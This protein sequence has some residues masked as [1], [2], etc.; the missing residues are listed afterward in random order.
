MDWL[1]S[2]LP[3]I[4]PLGGLLALGVWIVR[5][6][7]VGQL[8][9]SATHERILASK[10]ETIRVL[11]EAGARRDAQTDKLLTTSETT[12]HLLRSIAPAE[13]DS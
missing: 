1:L 5:Q 12:L 7:V 13:G 10:E 11:S 4:T 8:I 9:P 3:T 2:A 6:I